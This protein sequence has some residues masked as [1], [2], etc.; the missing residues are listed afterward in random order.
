MGERFREREGGVEVELRQ[1]ECERL[2]E[3]FR[4]REGEVETKTERV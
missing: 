4:E 1:R 3:R 2:G